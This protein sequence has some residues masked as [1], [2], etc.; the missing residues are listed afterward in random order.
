MARRNTYGEKLEVIETRATPD[1]LSTNL[2]VARDATD[3]AVR[4][5]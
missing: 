1:T 5:I 2:T 3:A 4:R